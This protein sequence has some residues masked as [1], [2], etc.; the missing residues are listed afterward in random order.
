LQKAA[1]PLI[2]PS[3]YRNEAKYL[4]QHFRAKR[5]FVLKSLK[6]IGF[7]IKV[8][9]EATFYIWLDVSELPEPINNGLA[10]FEECL[11]EKV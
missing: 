4:Q 5:D 10:F 11:K 2:E 8:P 6:E 9:P 3:K 7:N 1:I